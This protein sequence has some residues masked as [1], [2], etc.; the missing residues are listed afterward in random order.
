MKF[1]AKKHLLPYIPYVIIFYNEQEFMKQSRNYENGN[2][3]E[4]EYGLLYAEHME[5]QAELDSTLQSYMEIMDE[6]ELAFSLKNPWLTR[7]SDFDTEEVFT[8]KG[9]KKYITKVWVYRF[10]TVRL[11]FSLSEWKK[12]FP[13]AWLSEGR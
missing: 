10:D 11:E 9:V 3:D 5:K 6:I 13:Q 8:N 2:L 12:R 4:D 1:D 7:F